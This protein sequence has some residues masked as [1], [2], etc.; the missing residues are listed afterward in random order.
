MVW[1]EGN[2]VSGY[3][4]ND[5]VPAST[6]GTIQKLWAKTIE[7]YFK[8][9]ETAWYDMPENVVGVIVEPIS[10]KIAN[11]QDKK[12]L[13]YYIKGTEPHLD[14]LTIEDILPTIKEDWH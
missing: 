8:D 14:D 5:K 11:N 12:H 2:H 9:K 1:I 10:G 6:S 7:E 3:D 4:N 13:T